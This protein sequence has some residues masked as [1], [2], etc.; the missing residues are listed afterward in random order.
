MARKNLISTTIS[1]QEL[2]FKPGGTASLFEVQAINDSDRFAS[3]QLE[4]LAA[5]ADAKANHRNWYI[6]SPEVSTKKPPGSSTKFIVKIIDSPLSSFVGQVNLTVRVF[7]IE[8]QEE[9][10]QLIR[11]NVQEGIG[12]VALKVKLPVEEFQV[13]PQQQL[14]IA[15]EVYNVGTQAANAVL[16]L[17]GI[18]PAWL[19]EEKQVLHVPSGD[20][21]ETFFLCQIPE[22]AQ[23]IS[24]LYP[25]T[26]EA[27]LGNGVSSQAEGSLLILP[28][29]VVEFKCSPKEQRIPTRR[30]YFW[31]S[32]PVTYHLELEN[33][34]NLH[35]TCQVDFESEG[36][37]QL[38]ITPKQQIELVSGETRQLY[39]EAKV[40]RHWIGAAKKF[41]IEVATELSDP[42]LG[43][44]LPKSRLLQLKV[45]PLIP[46]WVLIGCGILS[47]WLIW[48]LS[49]L[50]PDNPF[51]GHQKAVNSVQMNG[52]ARNLIS[53]SND[54]TLALWSV[55]GF[56]DPLVNQFSGTIGNSQK[57]VRIV[58]YRP[59]NNNII[60]AGLE[61]GEIQLWGITGASGLVDAFSYQKDDRV[62]ALEF[63][64][65]SHY[66]FS[67]HGSG[68]VLQWDTTFRRGE[69]SKGNNRLVKNKQ[70]EFAVYALK[71]VGEGNKNLVVAGRYNQLLVWNLAT[72]RTFKVPYPAG[73]QDDYILSADTAEFAPHVLATA[74][75]QGNITIWNLRSC[76]QGTGKCE[77]IDRWQASNKGE[78]VRSVSLSENACYLASGGDSGKVTLWALTVEGKRAR[79][80]SGQVFKK[81]VSHSYDNKK[82]NSVHLEL[83]DEDIL[84]ASGSDDTQVRVVK[85]KRQHNLGCDVR[86]DLK[87]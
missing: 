9:S 40:K 44:T 1:A 11:L 54:Q 47:L 84:V 51:F 23:A 69:L 4:V 21:V 87:F 78:A 32:E 59:L 48:W 33:R 65:D 75:N 61:N 72:D 34:S 5:G 60:A 37:L 83:V 28:T 66:L 6:L 14:K 73:G 30:K 29:G 79:E 39:L 76:L 77:A 63:T 81:E 45:L 38:E 20:S 62:F 85:E 19:I 68:L 27:T 35:Q 17:G 52:L 71:L 36:K 46:T 86:E 7:S 16:K 49:W 57:A 80:S 13:Y 31:R 12:G 43:P 56:F 55:G 18:D 8:L 74:D 50:N 10:R 64:Q 41:L 70:F 58:R 53:G 3:F 2:T 22:T 67:G 15:I 26:A 42:R 25:F 82:F 24:Q